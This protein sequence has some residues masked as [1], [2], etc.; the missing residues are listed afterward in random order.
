[1]N[2]YRGRMNLFH[3]DLYRLNRIDDLDD[4][5]FASYLDTDGVTVVEWADRFG[6]LEGGGLRIRLTT[7]DENRRRI[8]LHAGDKVPPDLVA[9]LLDAWRRENPS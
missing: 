1:M 7:L 3:F 5:D 9:R 4:L 8:E 6:E 2:Q